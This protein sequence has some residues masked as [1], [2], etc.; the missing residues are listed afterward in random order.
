MTQ[1]VTEQLAQTGDGRELT[2]SEMQQA[3]ARVFFT[4][5]E[6]A[7]E[8]DAKSKRREARDFMPI[9]SQVLVFECEKD[10]F[11]EAGS[12]I[13]PEVAQE[14]QSE[15]V[16]VAVGCGRID[17]NNIFVATEVRP[18]DRVLYGR[19]AGT[20]IKLRGKTCRLMLEDEILGV[21]R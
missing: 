6:K 18:G 1:A 12:I 5:L 17:A 8:I 10:E 14:K 15:G 2:I 11:S 3:P 19:Y 16:V 13:I 4:N 9:R 21:I 20:E 7:L